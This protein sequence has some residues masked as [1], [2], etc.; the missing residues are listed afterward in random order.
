MPPGCGPTVKAA[1]WAFLPDSLRGALKR[2]GDAQY[3]TSRFTHEIPIASKSKVC[4][5]RV[6][7]V[8]QVGRDQRHGDGL[9]DL[10]GSTQV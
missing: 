4:A 6:A 1:R 3:G 9:G 7:L 10:P 2:E 5:F 8:E